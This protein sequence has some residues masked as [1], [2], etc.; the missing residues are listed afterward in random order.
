MTQQELKTWRISRS[1]TQEELGV[2]LGVTK[3]CV[4]RWEAGYRHIPPFLHLA[5]KWLE[6]EG[7]E[8]KDKGKLMKRERR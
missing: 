2:K 8:M 1:L 7:G 5:L 4:Y 6:N 3:T